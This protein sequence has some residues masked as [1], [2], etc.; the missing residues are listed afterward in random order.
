MPRVGKGGSAESA[1]DVDVK[2]IESMVDKITIFEAD[3]LKDVYGFQGV[4]ELTY[5]EGDARDQRQGILKRWKE[6]PKQG[7]AE[8]DLLR[9]KTWCKDLR[10]STCHLLASCREA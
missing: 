9:L 5:F 6:V 4:S 2:E 1:I 3:V 10:F 8:I 7:Y